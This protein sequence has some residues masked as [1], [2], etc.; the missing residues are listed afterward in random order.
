MK[1]WVQEGKTFVL[2]QLPDNMVSTEV[3]TAD[4]MIQ[5]TSF[6]KKFSVHD[7]VTDIVFL[8]SCILLRFIDPSDSEQCSPK[9][10]HL[11]ALD[12][13]KAL[14]VYTPTVDLE[15]PCVENRIG[16]FFSPSPVPLPALDRTRKSSLADVIYRTIYL[17]KG[18]PAPETGDIEGSRIAQHTLNDVSILLEVVLAAH[19]FA[20]D[21]P[22]RRFNF[23]F[24]TTDNDLRDAA[25]AL[26]G[27]R[28]QQLLHGLVP[29][30][31]FQANNIRCVDHY[32][33]PRLPVQNEDLLFLPTTSGPG[34]NLSK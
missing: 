3:W 2:K 29:S 5:P 33:P 4:A 20:R 27:S 17:P 8:D 13:C 14:L 9:P 24:L 30:T 31:F 25:S 12:H 10:L 16:C 21:N 34:K 28:Y 23:F 26:L 15:V 22:R 18:F 11:E 7:Y 19:F 6:Q 32:Q 1:S